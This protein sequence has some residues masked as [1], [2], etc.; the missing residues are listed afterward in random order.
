M[1]FLSINWIR[2]YLLILHSLIYPGCPSPSKFN[3]KKIHTSPYFTTRQLKSGHKYQEVIDR[4]QSTLFN[5]ECLATRI[6]LILFPSYYV[7]KVKLIGFLYYLTFI[8]KFNFS[9]HEIQ[10]KR[11]FKINT[12]KQTLCIFYS[13]DYKSATRTLQE[14]SKIQ[15]SKKK[16]KSLLQFWPISNQN[17]QCNGNL[18][19]H[20]F[21]CYMYIF[22]NYMP[23][24]TIVTFYVPRILL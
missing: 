12:S 19:R 2:C 22:K 17:S 8:I 14:I 18:A 23:F 20:F 7:T 6:F 9:S 13:S 21:L 5:K 16:I 3:T 11:I 10:N 15:T 1:C 4:S 24:Y